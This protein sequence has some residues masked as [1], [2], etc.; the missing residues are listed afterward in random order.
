MSKDRA[1]MRVPTA[2]ED[3]LRP[4]PPRRRFDRK[5]APV[6]DTHLKTAPASSISRRPW[7][8]PTVRKLIAGSAEAN[9]GSNTEGG[10]GNS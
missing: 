2:R 10:L 6:A 8:K 4:D 5:G 9:T 1:G 3:R 7:Q